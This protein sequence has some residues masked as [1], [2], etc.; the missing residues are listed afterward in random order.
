MTEDSWVEKALDDVVI[1]IDKG[2]LKLEMDDETEELVRKMYRALFEKKSEAEWRAARGTILE[3]AERAGRISEIATL[4]KCVE[5]D[6]NA[7]ADLDR[8]MVTLVCMAVSRMDCPLTVPSD[9]K[10]ISVKGGFC[11][12]L[13]CPVPEEQGLILDRI[14]TDL[15]YS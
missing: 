10:D 9:G 11:P 1:A 5:R 14:L 8:D 2:A 12:H 3:L 6:E 7:G 13:V 15:G 4:L